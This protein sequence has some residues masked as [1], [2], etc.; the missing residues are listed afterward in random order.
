M[1]ILFAKRFEGC[2]DWGS[3]IARKFNKLTAAYL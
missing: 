1:H 2:V 3:N